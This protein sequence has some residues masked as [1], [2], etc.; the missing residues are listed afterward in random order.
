MVALGLGT[1]WAGYYLFMYG[2][3]LIRGYN[4]GFTNLIHPAWPGKAATTTG[5][6]GGGGGGPAPKAA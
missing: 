6:S 1:V 2:Y 3:C 5:P 4:I